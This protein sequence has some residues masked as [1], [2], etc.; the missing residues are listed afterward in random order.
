MSSRSV[1]VIGEDEVDG[2]VSALVDR[3]NN[4]LVIQ[5]EIH[6]NIHRGIFYSA[7]T[8][9]E[10]FAADGVEDILLQV[11]T[12][13]HLI[14]S[15]A[16]TANAKAV[17]YENTTFSVA[18][19]A[20]PSHNRNRFS[21]NTSDLVVSTGPTIT[22]PGDEIGGSLLPAGSKAQAAGAIVHSFHEWILPAGNYLVR[23]TNLTN[24]IEKF[25]LSVDYYIPGQA[26]VVP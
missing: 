19:A 14:M 16:V 4:A 13:V 6:E 3:I 11:V 26:P 18:G 24:Q 1:K 21:S 10:A 7:G 25:S 23:V 12:P 8:I 2:R 22:L 15:I 9:N 5:D 17:L 20:V